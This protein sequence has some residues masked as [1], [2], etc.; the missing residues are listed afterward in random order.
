MRP[1]NIDA[2]AIWGG[3]DAINMR[4]AYGDSPGADVWDAMDG[5]VMGKSKLAETTIEDQQRKLEIDNLARDI[6]ALNRKIAAAT[7][8]K[9]DENQF[10]TE[11][12]MIAYEAGNLADRQMSL[13]G[14]FTYT[15]QSVNDQIREMSDAYNVRKRDAE[16]AAA[17][18]AAEHE[19]MPRINHPADQKPNI[20]LGLGLGTSLTPFS[21]ALNPSVQL[22]VKVH[23][24]LY[25]RIQL[26][27]CAGRKPKCCL[28]L[29]ASHFP[30]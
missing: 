18:A 29:Q 2:D 6:D 28:L 1:P 14:D 17:V 13:I 16:A 27:L 12:A 20:S 22:P 26:R 25:C 7:T 10:I 19:L 24:A 23:L 3:T 11:W 21:M 5:D 9:P 4:E 15:I 8:G 30:W